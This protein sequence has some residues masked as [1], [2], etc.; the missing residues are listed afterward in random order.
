MVICERCGKRDLEKNGRIYS[1][2]L[3]YEIEKLRGESEGTEYEI[4]CKKCF[5]ELAKEMRAEQAVE[6]L[7]EDFAKGKY[8]GSYKLNGKDVD[9][10]ELPEF[11]LVV[12]KQV[13]DENE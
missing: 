13:I 5:K 10:I 12:R 1:A 8:K 11:E 2:K 7:G 4:V 3:L 6:Q 9:V